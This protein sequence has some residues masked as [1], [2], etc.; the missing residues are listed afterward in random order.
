M[1][2]TESQHT[3]QVERQQDQ[4]AEQRGRRG[5]RGDVGRADRA[6]AEQAQVEQGIGDG[7]FPQHEQDEPG[8]SDNEGRHRRGGAETPCF[9]TGEAEQ[10]AEQ[11]DATQGRPRQVERAPYPGHAVFRK[12][13]ESADE[14]ARPDDGRE[15]EHA[16]PPE[17][18]QQ[19]PADV[20]RDDRRD[21]DDGG[22][23]PECLA[24]LTVVEKLGDVADRRGRH[25]TGPGGL[26][27]AKRDQ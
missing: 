24:P 1:D 4:H 13:D 7:A 2:R 6:Q 10:Q 22:V 21:A 16:A 27:D 18:G 14:D 20:E 25:R 26:H 11:A 3:T 8:D 17:C 15:P 23:D 9:A 5:P 19:R 12:D